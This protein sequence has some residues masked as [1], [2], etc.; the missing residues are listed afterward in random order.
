ME[1]KIKKLRL[2]RG[3]SLKEL[4][5]QTNINKSTLAS[6]ESRG[7]KPR[8]DKAKILADFFNVSVPYLMGY[9]VNDVLAEVNELLN[10][11]GSEKDLTE[12]EK[13]KILAEAEKKMSLTNSL[14]D[15]QSKKSNAK[16]VIED[17]RL[18][19]LVNVYR[20]IYWVY[21]GEDKQEAIIEL[22]E[23]LSELTLDNI[24]ILVKNA[25]FLKFQQE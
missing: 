11:V 21:D 16:A 2:E 6:Y 3:L 22:I 23:I 15:E 18:E 17:A 19:R 24:E 1:N 14:I 10:K 12:E 7:V 5:T 13:D 20:D 9:E 25:E 8:E 4:E